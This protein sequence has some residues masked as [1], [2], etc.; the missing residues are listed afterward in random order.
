MGVAG[1]EKLI[2]ESENKNTMKR[3]TFDILEDAA[4]FE[5]SHLFSWL[6]CAREWVPYPHLYDFTKACVELSNFQQWTRNFLTTAP[7]HNT[8]LPF[9][10]NRWVQWITLL[11]TFTIRSFTPLPMDTNLHLVLFESALQHMA[12]RPSG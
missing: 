6:P 9:T 4:K 3:I 11:V 8:I 10:R 12:D 1:V 7:E 5:M 2:F